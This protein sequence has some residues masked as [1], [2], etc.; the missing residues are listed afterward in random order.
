MI[1]W[2]MSY[3]LPVPEEVVA[4]H[5]QDGCEEEKESECPLVGIEIPDGQ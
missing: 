4:E 5:R 1:D 2:F 3:Q